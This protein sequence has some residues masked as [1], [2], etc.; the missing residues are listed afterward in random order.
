MSPVI[1]QNQNA[2]I[3]DQ[4]SYCELLES[5]QT[6]LVWFEKWLYKPGQICTHSWLENRLY[7]P[8]YGTNSNLNPVQPFIILTMRHWN[9]QAGMNCLNQL[10]NKQSWCE[11]LGPGT[12]IVSTCDSKVGMWWW[13]WTTNFHLN[14]YRGCTEPIDKKMKVLWFQW[15]LG[16]L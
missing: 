8:F 14:L 16:V 2:A 9:G 6:N 1:T 3:S 7:W 5:V 12:K 10:Q 4:F 13:L 15:N 11:S